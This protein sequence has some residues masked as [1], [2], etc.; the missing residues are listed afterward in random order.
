MNIQAI[1]AY[2]ILATFSGFYL[3]VFLRM[4]SQGLSCIAE[5]H[6]WIRVSET[7]MFAA[8]TAWSLV[9]AI[10]ELKRR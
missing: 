10:L 7:V 2:L 8:V 9:R 5:P 4:D 1:L 3:W 6:D